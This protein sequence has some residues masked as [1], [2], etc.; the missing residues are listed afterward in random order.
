MKE[1]DEVLDAYRR[2]PGQETLRDLLLAWD[3]LSLVNEHLRNSEIRIEGS[4]GPEGIYYLIS[5]VGKP[6]Q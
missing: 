1:A 2:R 6:P 3:Q 4:Y 5:G